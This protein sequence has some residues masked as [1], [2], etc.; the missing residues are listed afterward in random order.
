MTGDGADAHFSPSPRRGEG[1]GKVCFLFFL[2]TCHLPPV[3]RSLRCLRQPV[4]LCWRNNFISASSV[5]AFPRERMR[6]IT[7][8]RFAL[9]KTSDI[10]VGQ[11]SRLTLTFL[12]SFQME[13]GATPVLRRFA[14]TSRECQPP[15]HFLRRVRKHPVIKPAPL[16][17]ARIQFGCGDFAGLDAPPRFGGDALPAARP[18]P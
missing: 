15:R 11:A 4:I 17:I 7:A 13:T 10:N 1:R 12:V 16:G 14:I 9:V 6:D 18:A 3:T 5:A 8:D 2:V